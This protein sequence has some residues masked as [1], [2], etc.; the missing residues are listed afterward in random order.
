MTRPFQSTHLHKVIVIPGRRHLQLTRFKYFYSYTSCCRS[1]KTYNL[2]PHDNKI[3]NKSPNTGA[4]TTMFLSGYLYKQM[5]Y[6]PYAQGSAHVCRGFYGINT[7]WNISFTRRNI[8]FIIQESSVF[9]EFFWM[10]AWM[11]IPILL[12]EILRPFWISG[13]AWKIVDRVFH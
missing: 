8:N 3:D 1:V 13:R 2:I 10:P 7:I 5:H 9:H 6:Y 12:L 4:S 11:A